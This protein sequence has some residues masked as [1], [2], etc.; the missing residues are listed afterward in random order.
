MDQ[1]NI[2]FPL[3]RLRHGEHYQ[4]GRD[5]LKKVTPE[6]AQKYGFQSVYTPYAN[7][8]DVED[9]CYSKTQ[10]FLST[11]EIKALDQERGEV[12][13][14]IS[15]SI[16]A[17]AHSPVKETKE[18]AIR[19]DY[20]LKPHKYAYDMNYV[21]ETGSIANF[22]S[23]LKAEENVADVAKIGLTD[24]VALLEEKNEAFNVLYSSRSIDALGRSTSETMKTIRPKVDEAFKALV[25]A[26]NAIYQ[27]NELVTKSPETK[28]ELG[29]V[30]TQINAHLL[31]LQK[32]LIRD[33]VISGKT[34]NE[35][36]N[37]PDTPD[38]PV[39][40]EITAVYQKE[41]GDP[42]N[43]HRIERGKQ[44]AIEYQ[45]FTLKGQ[46]DMLEHVIGLVNDQDYIEW[47]KAATISNVTETSCEFT[48]VPDLT[49]GQY[50]VRIET[51][52]GGSPLVI[53]YPEPIT[54][55]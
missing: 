11:P 21:E 40:P 26:I 41:E 27:V 54:L 45:G 1:I 38:E 25:S 46:D 32:I 7:G 4:L 24:A 31:Q 14:F 19:L 39:T 51:Y 35:G 49:E 2:S 48:M 55:W 16:A 13:I 34:D 47:I 15:M 22:V 6:L 23:K 42:E 30:I 20:L 50:K 10:G 52:D 8:C 44:T 12:F 29:E 43:P 37:T 53:E 36:T 3:Y 17:A 9:A 18:A 28:E 33:G 5:V